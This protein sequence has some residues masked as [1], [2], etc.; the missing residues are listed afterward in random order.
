[1]RVGWIDVKPYC[2]NSGISHGVIREK[3]TRPI[4][5][6]MIVSICN[7]LR[8]VVIGTVYRFFISLELFR[9]ELEV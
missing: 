9:K 2:L 5:N 6:Q 8:D 3:S 7:C 1:M 4:D